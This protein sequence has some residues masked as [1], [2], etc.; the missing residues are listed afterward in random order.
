MICF[1]GCFSGY[2]KGLEAWSWISIS[3]SDGV[4][5]LV[6]GAGQHL[7]LSYECSHSTRRHSNLQQQITNCLAVLFSTLLWHKHW[8]HLSPT[9]YFSNPRA[10][11]SS[12]FSF[13]CL[14]PY[15]VYRFCFLCHFCF[16][17]NLVYLFLAVLISSALSI[18]QKDF[19]LSW[20]FS[21]LES[22]H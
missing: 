19:W 7:E 12:F 21:F 14:M 10:L 6:K 18:S 8:H 11:C 9:V 3:L 5:C 13:L 4:P 2:E 1:L 15:F 16:V 17:R 22:L 20:I